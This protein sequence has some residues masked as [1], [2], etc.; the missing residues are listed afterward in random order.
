VRHGAPPQAGRQSRRR[1]APVARRLAPVVRRLA[2]GA[3]RLAPGARRLPPVTA[4]AARA[5]QGAGRAGTLAR[6]R[7]VLKKIIDR[8]EGTWL[9]H[10]MNVVVAAIW[11]HDGV[12]AVLYFRET[13]QIPSLLLCAMN[14]LL[15]VFYMRRRRATEVGTSVKVVVV[16]N[17]GTFG[18]FLYETGDP[19]H[20][21]VCT[22][23]VVVMSAA[24]VVSLLAFLSLGRSWGIIPANRGLKTGGLYR[25]VR[26]PIYASYIIFDV[27][28]TVVTFTW[29][30][31][32]VAAT[33]ALILYARARYEEELLSR[34]PEYVAY[35]QRTRSM[36]IPGLL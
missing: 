25:V 28:Y 33:I 4:L 34:D 19:I 23:C 7:P 3:R 14:A 13:G 21:A 35:A 2:P 15:V 36:L 9:F 32:A 22:P 31:L 8:I 20:P 18:N 27:A 6:D 17:L 10:V 1:L 5:W 26:H 12:K 24:L 11:V 16:A 29:R 30:N